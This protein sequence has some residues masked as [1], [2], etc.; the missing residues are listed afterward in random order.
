MTTV[1]EALAALRE[2]WGSEW[3]VWV[4]P[5]SVGGERWCARRHG[6][7]LPGLCKGCR[8]NQKLIDYRDKAWDALMLKYGIIIKRLDEAQKKLN[9][10]RGHTATM[11]M[12]LRDWRAM[13]IFQ[14]ILARQY[15]RA[16]L[17]PTIPEAASM[18][19]EYADTLETAS[20][21]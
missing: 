19:Y 1:D 10:D 14:S 18:A 2:R 7:P 8:S 16:D 20:K 13:M 15:P 21:K 17:V 9:E 5:L 4:V 11:G 12:N 6:D 3:E